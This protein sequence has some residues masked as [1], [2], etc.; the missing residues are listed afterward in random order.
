MTIENK[1][2]IGRPAAPR[3][4][5]RP[6]SIT[7]GCPQFSTIPLDHCYVNSSSRQ[8]MIFRESLDCFLM[9]YRLLQFPC[10]EL[11]AKTVFE[12]G[13]RRRRL[14]S[15]VTAAWCRCP[16]PKRPDD[17]H[18]ITIIIYRLLLHPW[19]SENEFP[20]PAVDTRPRLRTAANSVS[21]LHSQ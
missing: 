1:N 2:V 13:P 5:D 16:T 10:C 3:C 8:I 17:E 4:A 19:S 20:A 6:K 21:V 15:R 12:D 7:Y 14:L 18:R 9:I 11:E